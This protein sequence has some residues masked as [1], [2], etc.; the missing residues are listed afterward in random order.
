MSARVLDLPYA[1]VDTIAKSDSAWR[2]DITI[3]KALA[4]DIRILRQHI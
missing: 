2:R 1:Y 4:D 3:A